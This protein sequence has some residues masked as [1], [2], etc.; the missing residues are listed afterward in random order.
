MVPPSNY[1]AGHIPLNG[2]LDCCRTFCQIIQSMHEDLPA[3]L[4]E[5][6]DERYDSVRSSLLATR[7]LAGC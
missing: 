6:E 5:Q 4:E 2:K 1:G 7:T 3:D